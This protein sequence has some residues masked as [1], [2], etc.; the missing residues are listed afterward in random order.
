[1]TL[2]QK[3]RSKQ[4]TLG[5]WI[6]IPNQAVIEIMSTAGFDWLT[7]DIEHSA[8]DIESIQNL[9][10]FIQ[11]K[12]I[13]AFVRVYANDEVIIKRV[14]DAG[15]D[16][17]IVPMIKS[18]EDAQKLVD[19]VYYPPKGKR[20]VGLSRAQNYGIGFDQYQEKLEKEIVIIAQIEH[21]DAI[22]HLEEILSIDEIDSTLIGPYDLSASMNKPGQYDLPE[23]KE[24]IT[25]YDQICDDLNK[26]KGAHVIQSDHSFTNAKIDLGYTFLAFSL[27]FFFLGDKAR[28]QMQ[29]LKK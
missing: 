2:K 14:L 29:L 3:I 6:T 5:S 11:A 22:H 21:I 26:P 19:Y 28:E 8:V 27:D 4:L 23:V 9:I 25:K 20:G 7:I 24:A 12:N 10:G 13:K 1:M 16:G 18:K 15:A 17:V